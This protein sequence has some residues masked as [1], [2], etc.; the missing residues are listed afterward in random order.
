MSNHKIS[1]QLLKFQV[2]ESM[3]L[4]LM[5][6]SIMKVLAIFGQFI[7]VRLL[8]P[9]IFGIYAIIAF[10]IG[11]SEILTD[12]GF[13]QS[14]I[15]KKEKPTDKELSTI[16]YLKI[17]TSLLIVITIYIFSI[18]IINLFNQ[19]SLEQVWMLRVLALIS[20]VKPYKTITNSLLE[21][22]LNYYAISKIDV[23]GIMSY[24][25]IVL[26]LALTGFNV[27]SFIIA[28]VGKE[29]I[30][31]LLLFYFKRWIP[32]FYFNIYEIGKMIKFGAYIQ[33]GAV[34]SH[35]KKSNIPIIGGI[36]SSPY[37][38]GL[39]DLGSKVAMIPAI[40]MDNY[41][42]VA[43]SG[44]SKIQENIILLSKSVQKSILILNIINFLFIALIF[45]YGEEFV[46][47]ILTPKW[48]P[49]LPAIYWF[50]ACTFFYGATVSIN[51]ALLAIGRS[52]ELLYISVVA[53]LIELSLSFILFPY[54]G[55]SSIA[56][57]AFMGIFILF[58]L[59]TILAN[60]NKIF[61]DYK[62]IYVNMV[63]VFIFT[64]AFSWFLK[65]VLF[66]EGLILIFEVFLT[67]TLYI[68]LCFIFYKKDLTEVMLLII[69][70]IKSRSMFS[71]G[72]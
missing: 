51:H 35:L 30:E 64:V 14:I 37:G 68:I 52:K 40:I 67:I 18:S 65:N 6:E 38:V 44:F 63:L 49:A 39:L 3:Y 56:F 72:A 31:L 22:D 42:R 46:Y 69:K 41:G 58:I 32:L 15:Q 53:I 1:P 55:F 29:L 17:F 57:G 59:S 34:I 21:R 62:K 10:I 54:F 19:L 43:F 5:R 23:F 60:K 25:V 71:Y 66:S 12:I 9:E 48:L 8:A 33:A 7:L 47:Y 24:Y 2:F 70:S 11:T 61:V 13:S 27:W 4:L 20:M 26:P 36:R 50:V 16:F 45:G 28:V